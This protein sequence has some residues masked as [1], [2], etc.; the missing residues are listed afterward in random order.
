MQGHM[1]KDI[2]LDALLMAVMRRQP[3]EE[4]IVHSDQGSQYGSDSWVRFCR[5]HGLVTSMS[6]R[7]NC[8]DNAA[9]ESFNS[10]LKKE[11]IRGRVYAT[12][13][14]A[15]SDIFEYIEGFYNSRRRHSTIGMVSPQRYESEHQS[16][17]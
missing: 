6:G 11:R 2:V 9:M 17:G 12:R 3:R 16:R 8:Y 7:G 5:D 14:E 10:T 4:V 13:A 1:R 15:K